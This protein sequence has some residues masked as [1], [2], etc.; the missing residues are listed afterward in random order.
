MKDLGQTSILDIKIY[1]DK[2]RRIRGLSQSTYMKYLSGSI[3]NDKNDSYHMEEVEA[4]FAVS[5]HQMSKTA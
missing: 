3:L 1:E 5:R 2:L 4:R